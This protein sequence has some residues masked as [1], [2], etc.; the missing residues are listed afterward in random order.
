MAVAENLTIVFV[1]GFVTALAT[2][3]GAVPFFFVDDFSD[4]WNVGLWGVASGIMVTV[5]VFG[6]ADEGLAYASSGFPTL[7]VGGVLAGVM[8]V[9][10]SDRVLGSVDLSRTNHHSGDKHHGD[11]YDGEASDPAE[12]R[13]NGTG[14]GHSSDDPPLEATVFVEGDLKKLVLIL[15]ILT[16]H[17]FPEGVAVGVSF[18]ELGLEGGLSILGVSIP[19]LAVFMTI[20]IS[21]H[22]IPEGTAIAIPMRAMGLSNWRMVGAA[23][24]SSLPQPIG[25]VIAFVFV[26]WAETFLPFG[27]GFAAGAM[28][29]LV[30][31]EFIPEALETGADLPNRGRRELLVGFGAGVVAMLPILLV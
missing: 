16:V 27:F 11:E 12:V 5:S 25:A 30:A 1:A 31:T 28:V 18:A 29:Y 14:H 7:L 9:E 15:G 17:S 24:F 26:S 4:R 2:G 21:I 19:L 23:I 3:L 13:V 10:V 20:A 8:L 22:N 6:L